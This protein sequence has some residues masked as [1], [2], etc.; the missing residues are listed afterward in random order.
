MKHELWPEDD[1]VPP[2]IAHKGEADRFYPGGGVPWTAGKAPDL[3]CGHNT[4]TTGRLRSCGYCGSMHPADVAAA[5]RAGAKPHW[6]DFKYGWPHKAYIDGVPNP[7]AGM[8]CSTTSTGYGSKK[9]EQ[10]RHTVEYIERT[11]GEWVQLANYNDLREKKPEFVGHA[12]HRVDVERA[13][14]MQKFYTVHLQDATPEDRETIERALGKHFM[15]EADGRIRWRPV[16]PPRDPVQ[17]APDAPSST[18]NGA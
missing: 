18:F 10:D 4:Y 8:R 9:G 12:W 7:Y 17:P 11:G 14:T 13:T 2:S 16:D 3:T 15:F 6:A 5:I 1:T